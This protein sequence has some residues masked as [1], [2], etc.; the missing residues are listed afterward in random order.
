VDDKPLNRQLFV[1]LLTPL[2]F[3][4]KEACNGQEAINLWQEWNPHLIWMDMRMP[5][6]DGYE[7]TRRIK[8]TTQGQAVAV[9]ALTASVFEEEKAVVLSAGCDDFVRKPFREVEIFD[10]MSKHIGVQYI[11]DNSN[12][13]SRSIRIQESDANI[14]GALSALPPIW[15]ESLKQAIFRADLELIEPIVQK[16]QQYDP[17]LADRLQDYFDKF[18]YQTILTLLSQI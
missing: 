4:V 9:I 3:A 6:M 16:I 8:S 14:L 17:F 18:E 15:V 1:K 13:E 5:V 7:A 10:M 11:Y 12:S 2:G